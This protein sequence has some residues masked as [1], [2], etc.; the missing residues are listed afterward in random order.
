MNA[1]SQALQ[2]ISLLVTIVLAF[3]GW[4]I[5]HRSARE[6][7]RRKD[8]LD[9]TNKRLNE[10]Y[11]PLYVVSEVGKTAY[12]SLLRKLGRDA[13]F[14]ASRPFAQLR[15]SEQDEWKIW[16]RHVYMP[17]NETIERLIVNNAYLIREEQVPKCLL[18][19]VTHVVGYR[20]MLAKWELNDY[21][22]YQ[23]I[24]DFP[25]GLN[26]YASKSYSELK[27]EQTHLIGVTQKS[28][29]RIL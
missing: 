2:T 10:F 17:L 15:K 29:T 14:D 4:L 26:E 24:M 13:V 11:G 1:L 7:A 5:A 16:V 19:F 12:N 25:A 23:S 18:D 6:L 3:C 21:T 9:L 22:E 20:A 27:S 8:E 28:K